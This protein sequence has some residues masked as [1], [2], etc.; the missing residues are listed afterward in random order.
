[1]SRRHR[2]QA[3]QRAAMPMTQPTSGNVV[4][5]PMSVWQS[6]MAHLSPQ[7][8]TAETFSPGAPLIPIP[9][10]TPKAGPRQFAYL[11]GYNLAGNDRTLLREYIPAFDQLRLLAQTYSAIGIAERIWCDLI[12]RMELQ[13]TLRS[14]LKA[15]GASDKQFQ[16]EISGYQ[17]FF[18]KPDGCDDIH[19]WLRKAIVEQTQIDAL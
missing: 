9:G 10:I 14:D 8:Q 13:V 4:T 2:K 17:A 1:M 5:I 15:T 11:P 7:K 16:K 6:M 12:P 18:E 19:E 3:I